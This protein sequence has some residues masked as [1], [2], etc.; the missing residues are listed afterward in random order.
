MFLRSSVLCAEEYARSRWAVALLFVRWE[1][2]DISITLFDVTC[3]TAER[4]CG[5][6]FMNLDLTIGEC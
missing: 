1:Q 6:Q 5:H 2:L 4:R 3:R